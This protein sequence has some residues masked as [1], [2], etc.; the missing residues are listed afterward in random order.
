M[1]EAFFACLGLIDF[2]LSACSY[3]VIYYVTRNCEII[4]C[5][6]GQNNMPNGKSLI[7]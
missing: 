5:I 7:K 1:Q 4:K 6:M 3:D 2:C